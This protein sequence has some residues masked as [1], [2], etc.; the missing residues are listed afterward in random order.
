M[1]RRW[2]PSG[3]VSRVEQF[4]EVGEEARVLHLLL[5]PAKFEEVVWGI[6]LLLHLHV[7]FHHNMTHDPLWVAFPVCLS[8]GFDLTWRCIIACSCKPLFSDIITLSASLCGQKCSHFFKV[9]AE[10]THVPSA[11]DRIS[12]FAIRFSLFVQRI[13]GSIFI[14]LVT[15]F[16]LLFRRSIR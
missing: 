13:L 14:S 2:Y 3:V 16:L 11:H 10:P 12:S 1:S 9:L 5:G 4:L 8:V 6:E 15:L 7:P